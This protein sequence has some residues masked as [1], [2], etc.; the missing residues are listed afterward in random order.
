MDGYAR[1]L[2]WQCEVTGLPV[3]VAEHRFAAP[4]RWRFD[5]AWLDR[6]LAV[7]IEGGIW[8]KGRHVRGKGFEK[9][10]EK[11]NE[12]ALAGWR[13]LRFSTG[14]VK[15]GRALETLSRCFRMTGIGH[16]GSGTA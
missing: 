14:M 13:T 11:Y 6:M 16:Q 12:A 9:D 3:P 1:N 7:E 15:D 4:R 10:M 5:L 8:T 2:Q